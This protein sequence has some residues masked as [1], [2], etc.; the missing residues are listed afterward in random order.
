[1]RRQQ[2][3]SGGLPRFCGRTPEAR[4]QV[5]SVERAGIALGMVLM[6]QSAASSQPTEDRVRLAQEGAFILRRLGARREFARCGGNVEVW[7]PEYSALARQ[8]LQECLAICQELGDREGLSMALGRLGE[9]VLCEGAYEEAEQYYRQALTLRQAFGSTL[10]ADALVYNLGGKIA[11]H[12]GEYQQAR[13]LYELS[14]A[15]FKKMNRKPASAC[16]C[17][18]LGDAALA[19]GDYTA[20]KEHHLKALAMMQQTA[21]HWAVSLSGDPFGAAYSLDR[22]GDIALA[23]GEIGPAQGYYRQAHQIARDHPQ[24]GLTLDVL[25]SQAGL[26]AQGGREERAVELATLVLHHPAAGIRVQRKA[27]GLLNRLEFKI[28]RMPLAA[29]QERAA[30]GTCR[31]RYGSCCRN[32]RSE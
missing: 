13:Q 19:M 10:I 27:Q 8:L 4:M 22:L 18:Y 28:R 9:L 21:M 17:S 20:A 16:L 14:L 12:R 6:L 15:S 29:A 25:V 2:R 32:W 30:R 23:R 31:P 11:Y 24:V 1:M 3:P 26:L 5:G 7:G